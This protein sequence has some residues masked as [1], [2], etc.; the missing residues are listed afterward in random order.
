MEKIKSENNKTVLKKYFSTNFTHQ[1]DSHDRE[2]SNSQI[3]P[4]NEDALKEKI[5]MFLLRKN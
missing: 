2:S 1:P 3:D 4:D 5:Q